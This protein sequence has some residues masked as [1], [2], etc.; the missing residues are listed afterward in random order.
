MDISF[1]IKNQKGDHIKVA[2]S[3][4]DIGSLQAFTD[5]LSILSLVFYD[6]TLV[7]VAGKGY[8][9]YR[10][11]Y[12]ISDTLAR[13]LNENEDGVLCFYC[14]SRTDILRKDLTVSPQEYRSKLFSRM[15]DHYIHENGLVDYINHCVKVED[16]TDTQFAHFICRETHRNAV[17]EIGKI[18]KEK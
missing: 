12:V 16:G 17:E 18:L 13:F 10:T 6:V 4:Y 5:D 7:R 2:L 3:Y 11:P 14:D 9:G 8:V 15:F 1:D